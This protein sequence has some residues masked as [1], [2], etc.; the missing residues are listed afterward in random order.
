MDF[1]LDIVT[2]GFAIKRLRTGPVASVGVKWA[3]NPAAVGGSRGWQCARS[4]EVTQLQPLAGSFGCE[5]TKQ[6][7]A[8][9]A[10]T[11]PPTTMIH[12][13]L[14]GF[15]HA[16]ATA[17][18]TNWS[19]RRGQ[20]M[21]SATQPVRYEERSAIVRWVCFYGQVQMSTVPRKI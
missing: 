13:A 17:V 21:Q 2:F 10:Q 14:S 12:F 5:W 3:E 20:R 1:G 11:P 8:A 18:L 19:R 16:S 7:S 4:Q 9:P 15:S 6:H